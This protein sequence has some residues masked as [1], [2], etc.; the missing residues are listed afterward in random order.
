MFGVLL[1]WKVVPARAAPLPNKEVDPESS[2]YIQK[3]LRSTEE[4][5]ERRYQERLDSY[6]RRNFKVVAHPSLRAILAWISW[7]A[8][9]RFFTCLSHL[10][11]GTCFSFPFLSICS[12]F[13]F[14]NWGP[15]AVKHTSAMPCTSPISSVVLQV[16]GWLNS[17]LHI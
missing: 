3:L 2:P 15:P 4:N 12:Y 16:L 13:C 6:N 17:L 8:W 7:I 5:R 10:L 11:A 14:W 9:T 1:V